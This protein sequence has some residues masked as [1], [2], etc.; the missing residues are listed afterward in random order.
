M[1]RFSSEI[2]MHKGLESDPRVFS[3]KAVNDEFKIPSVKK[4]RPVPTFQGALLIGDPSQFN[5]FLSIDVERYP[6][7][8]KATAISS[9]A[10]VSSTLSKAPQPIMTE[11]HYEI[12]CD[13]EIGNDNED[14][15]EDDVKKEQ[16][17]SR[18]LERGYLYGRTIVPISR[19]DEENL[20]FQTLKALEIVGFIP[21]DGVRD[22]GDCRLF[23]PLLIRYRYAPLSFSRKQAT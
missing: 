21:S 15:G 16:V 4:V 22:F 8:K 9:S 6:C 10:Y 17:D 14:V 3:M 11:R 1:K 12:P 23:E 7:T 19:T 5:D 13:Q 20:R 18:D 2:V